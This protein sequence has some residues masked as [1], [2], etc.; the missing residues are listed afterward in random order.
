MF[1]VKLLQETEPNGDLG[2]LI[3]LVLFFL[4]MM[5]IVGWLVSRRNASRPE[6]QGEARVQPQANMPDDLKRIEGIGPKVENLLNSAGIHSFADLADAD[7]A[8]LQKK[9]D[10]AGLQ[11]MDPRGWIEQARLAAQG[12][13]EELKKLQDELDGG[14]KTE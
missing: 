11:M 4:L 3:Y 13:W 7:A 1:T 10:E 5:V 14:R 12:R 6:V 8:D 9:L 2:W